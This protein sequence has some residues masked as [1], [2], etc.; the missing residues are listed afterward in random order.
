[1]KA[2][3]INRPL[4]LPIPHP[5]VITLILEDEVTGSSTMAAAVFLQNTEYNP[6]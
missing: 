3:N 2:P 1:M 6:N 5:Q 4:L